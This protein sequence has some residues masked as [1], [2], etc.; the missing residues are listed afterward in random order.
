MLAL[1]L[2]SVISSAVLESQ[3]GSSESVDD[4]IARY[5]E[6]VKKDP[7]SVEAQCG[8]ANAYIRKYLETH[9]NKLVFLAKMVVKKAERIDLHSHLPDL[10]MA[11]LFIAMDKRD[12]AMHRARKALALDPQNVEVQQ[13]INKLGGKVVE[14]Q[15]D[16]DTKSQTEINISISDEERLTDKNEEIIYSNGGRYKGNIQNGVLDGQGIMIWANGDKYEGEW[17]N[18]QQ[19]GQGTMVWAN[20]YKYEGEWE[21]SRHNGHGIMIWPNGDKYEGEWYNGKQHGQGI[22]LFSNGGKYV[23]EYKNSI[24][25]GGWYYWPG[26]NVTWSYIDSQGKWTHQVSKP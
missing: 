2:I 4:S 25:S 18:G 8:L 7:E 22:Y 9:E 19:H 23:G 14:K 6:L 17:K 26:G 3:A 11:R 16:S 21:D 10:S 13:L 20:G 12:M 5:K 15:N 24:S 1:I